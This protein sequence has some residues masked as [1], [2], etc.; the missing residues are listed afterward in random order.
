MKE[1]I[2][3]EGAIIEEGV[4]IGHGCFIGHYSIIRKDVTVGDNS[5]IR[6]LCFIAQGVTIGSGVK[7]F[8]LSNISKGSIIEDRAYIGANVLFTNTNKIS[9]GR[10]YDPAIEGIYIEYG[11]RIASGVSI[12]PGVRIGRE[13][14]IGLGSVVT[15]DCDP[16]W[17]YFGNPAEK[18]KPVPE[19]ER[20]NYESDYSG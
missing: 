19:E 5:E 1:T 15:K 14:L 8:Q 4:S 20:L 9:H 3:Q 2:I 13:A 11:A 7:I 16:F 10:H 6:Q 12:L 17:I 18:V